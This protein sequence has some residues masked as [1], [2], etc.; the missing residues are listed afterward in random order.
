M[1]EASTT[2]NA[3]PSPDAVLPPLDADQLHALRDVG[4]AWGQSSNGGSSSLPIDPS[5]GRQPELNQ[6]TRGSRLVHVKPASG[7]PDELEATVDD[8]GVAL[9]PQT[10]GH[11][12]RRAVLGPPLKSTA[13]VQERMRKLIAL[14]VL[15]ADA[16]SSVAYG[17]EAMLA[18]L[19]LAGG[20]GLGWS[21]PISG[22]IAFLM[23]A[24]GMSYRQTIRAYPH[25]GGSYIVAGTNLGRV[26]GLMAAAGLITDYVLTVAVSISSGLAALTSAVPSL[27][28]AVVPIGLALIALLLAANLRGV[29]QAGAV[30]AAPTYAFI[31][32]IALLVIVG[33]IDAGRRG[34]H[35]LP[36]PV[37]HASQGVGLLL[38]LRAFASGS[39]A[40]TGIEAISNAVPAFKPVEWRNARTSLTWMVG[41]LITMFVGIIALVHLDGVVPESGQ[42]VLSQLA[43]LDFGA[44][45]LYDFT[46]AATA[47]VLLL[48]ADTAYNDFPRVMFLLA[49]DRFAPTPFL[50]MGDRLAFNN[51][52]VVLSIVAALVFA[53]FNG[54]TG[55]L[56]PLYAVGVFLA[57]TLSQAGMVVHWWRLR[58]PR[59]RASILV[60]GVGCAMSAIVFLIA[61][62][63]KF[64]AGAWVSLL[65]VAAFTSVALLTRHH[66]DGVADAIAL[67]APAAREGEKEEAPA[68][69]SNLVIV[70]VAH[71]DRVTVRALAYAA[72]L[73]QPVLALHVSPTE[74]ESQ[75]FHQYWTAWGNHVPLEVIQS[76][77][78]AVIP[79]I[80]AYIESAH[81]QRSD[82]TLTVIVPDL[83]V[84]HWWQRPLHENTAVRLRHALA[85]LSKVVVTSVPLHV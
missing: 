54:N 51:G 15:S 40:M 1:L 82:L 41:L 39:T 53:A 29:R 25:G 35:P 74:E 72:S 57:F 11:R 68:E 5:L 42:T 71:L 70:P 46:Q 22:A 81:A 34:F 58:G 75:R 16:L 59:W 9:D 84:R 26:P 30:F 10:V 65:I 76:P 52:I 14:P 85:P 18:V 79:P 2:S 31:F 43:H 28:S 7:S 47:L 4:S 49:R 48:A 36:A 55:S 32:A 50:R 21:L 83:A 77:Y 63:T 20:P 17:P 61:C 23:L 37:L 8:G 6:P 80:V 62:I 13:I 69:V 3:P 73:R 64:T 56:I 66:F 45:P 12:I 60:N 24:V 38:V 44:G 19:V 67:D 33:L 78:R 27:H